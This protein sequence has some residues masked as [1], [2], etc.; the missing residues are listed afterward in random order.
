MFR[1]DGAALHP[2]YLIP[3]GVSDAS[4]RISRYYKIL[5]KNYP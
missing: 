4:H 1:K 2:S 5:K 3:P